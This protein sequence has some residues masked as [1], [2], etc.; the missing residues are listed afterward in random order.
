VQEETVMKVQRPIRE[1]A[2]VTLLELVGVVSS[3]AATDLETARVINHLLLTRRV[4]F[5][6]ALDREEID[7]L[8]S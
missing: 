2:P 7:L 4:Q 5:T 3:F 6:E 8:H 1:P